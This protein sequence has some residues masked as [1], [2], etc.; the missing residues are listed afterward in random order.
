[1]PADHK[2]RNDLSQ[3]GRSRCYPHTQPRYNGAWN[4]T[5]TSKPTVRYNGLDLNLL[6]ALKAL[7]TE[8]SVTRA[9]EAVHVTQSAMSGILARLREY[10]GDPLIVP[11]GRK[12]ELTPLAESLLEPLSDVLLRIDATIATLPHFDPQ[13]TRRHFKVVASDYVVNVLMLDV[14]REV[15]RLAPGLT[16]EFCTPSESSP[17]ELEAGQVD[18][19]IAPERFTLS[20]Q[21]GA[22]LFEDSYTLVVDRMHPH[23]GDTMDLDQYLALGHVALRSGK[24]GLPLFEAWFADHHGS[25]RRVEVTAHSFQ[26][27]PLLTIGTTRVA[28]MHARLAHLLASIIPVR[29]VRPTFEIPKLVEVLQWHRYRDYDPGSVW[30]RKQIIDRAHALQPWSELNSSTCR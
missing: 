22:D 18:F 14:L 23:V 12:M 4:E 19:V 21:S 2:C 26:I 1:M 5:S 16:V 11:V 3:R 15:H 13:T 10:F 27:L 17:E 8:K 9:G 25:A 24:P 28:T 20:S 7:L 30:F 6:T 29:V